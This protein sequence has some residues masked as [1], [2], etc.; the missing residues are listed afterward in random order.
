MRLFRFL[1]LLTAVVA[2]QSIW[3]AQDGCPAKSCANQEV[4]PVGV[5]V[6]VD[7]GLGLQIDFAKE[8]GGKYIQMH[9]PA[10]ESR[11]AEK[12]VAFKAR[13]KELGLVPTVVFCGFDGESYA[14]IPTTQKTVGLVP[15]ATR[16]S[17]LAEVKEIADFANNIGC[18]AVGI[19]IGFIP[20][21]TEDAETHAQLVKI[22]QDLCDYLAKRGQ[23][24]H[25]ETGQETA[26]GLLAF[27]KDVNRPNIFVNFDPANMILYG[28][29][30]PI[31]ALKKI[32]KYVGSCHCKDALWAKNPGKEWGQEVP[33][34]EGQVDAKK[35]FETLREIGYYGPVTIEREIPDQPERQKKEIIQAKQ[36]IESIKKDLR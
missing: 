24:L 31:E 9:T 11:T 16:A 15:A 18:A 4:W 13:L 30:N 23:R 17:R 25:L 26:D 36:L 5:F 32:G 7:A 12:A 8:I 19:H 10:K 6:S 3:A 35:F 20:P 14:D 1:L 21:V 22:A 2:S 34:G 29:G 27:L 28:S 33:F